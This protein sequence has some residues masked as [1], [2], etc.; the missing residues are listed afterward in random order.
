MTFATCASWTSRASALR[1]RPRPTSRS[2]SSVRYTFYFLHPHSPVP[3]VLSQVNCRLG[4]IERPRQAAGVAGPGPAA[5]FGF[6]GP[7]MPHPPAPVG[8]D[9]DGD[10]DEH[11]SE[12]EG[13]EENADD[14]Q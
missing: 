13:E 11:G 8:T 1:C 12:G 4:V 3:D 10:D 5:M 7:L 14:D 9:D 6:G 2:N